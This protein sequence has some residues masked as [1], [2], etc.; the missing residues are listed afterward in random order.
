MTGY[1][2]EEPATFE[3]EFNIHSPNQEGTLDFAREQKQ[4]WVHRRSSSKNNDFYSEEACLYLQY[5]SITHTISYDSFCL[6]IKVAFTMGCPLA[7]CC[8]R[9]CPPHESVQ[10]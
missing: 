9:L 2:D 4:K 7:F 1:K 8:T 6:Q 5:I 10:K 3:D